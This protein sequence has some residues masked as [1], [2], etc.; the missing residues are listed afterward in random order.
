MNYKLPSK[1]GKLV[2][3]KIKEKVKDYSQE[4]YFCEWCEIVT[5]IETIYHKGKKLFLCDEC[6]I[7]A[8]KGEL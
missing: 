7:K 6:T 5:K 2:S 1:M 3:V 8:D 4:E